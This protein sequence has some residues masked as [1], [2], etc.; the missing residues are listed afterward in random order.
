[1]LQVEAQGWPELRGVATAA[2]VLAAGA[3][4]RQAAGLGLVASARL[5]S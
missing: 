4:L 2:G 3:P 5:A 1:M